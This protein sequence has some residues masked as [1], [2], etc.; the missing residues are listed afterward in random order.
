[1]LPT[2]LLLT[3]LLATCPSI[4]PTPN[5]LSTTV[6]TSISMCRTVRKP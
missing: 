6:W 2:T 3:T 4:S 1:M 5:S